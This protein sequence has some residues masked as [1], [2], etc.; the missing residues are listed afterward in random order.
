MQMQGRENARDGRAAAAPP[1][2]VD[3]VIAN[4]TST[5]RSSSTSSHG[6]DQ[7]LEPA[8]T[9]VRE[10]GHVEVLQHQVLD[11]RPDVVVHDL[12]L[13]T[14]TGCRGDVALLLKTNLGELCTLC[15]AA[16]GPRRP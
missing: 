2:G 1:A 8:A 14:C 4:P 9:A 13:V 3:V 12:L 6:V 10:Q 7:V 16:G 5:S 11:E 15:V